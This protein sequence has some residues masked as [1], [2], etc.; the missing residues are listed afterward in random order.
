V[1]VN[2]NDL[3]EETSYVRAPIKNTKT[4]EGFEMVNLEVVDPH[5][6]VTYLFNQCGLQIDGDKVQTFWQHHRAVKSPFMDVYTGGESHIPLGLYGDGA[7]ARQIAYQAPEKVIGLF[8]NVP[9]FRPKSARHARYLLFSIE[10]ELCFGRK[11]LNAVYNRLT[12]SLNHLFHGRWP[13]HGPRGERLTS[14]KAG[15]L[16]T[17]DGKQFAVVEHRGDWSFMKWLFGLKSSWKAGTNAPVCYQCRAYGKGPLS[18][19][20]YH[21]GE[22][23]PAWSTEHTLVS[24]L[25]EEMPATD[26][27]I[28]TVI[29]CM[30]QSSIKVFSASKK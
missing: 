29:P 6:L 23:A 13:T 10:E 9:L 4:P 17:P 21:V 30:V 27:C 20:Y 18:E 28:S 14:P 1:K 15:S 24:F 19:R 26:P 11:T 3:S 25:A 7:R 8:L 16:I 2:G 12:W 22:N 5:Q